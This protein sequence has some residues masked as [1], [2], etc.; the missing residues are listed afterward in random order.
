M[1]QQPAPEEALARIAAR[2][3]G[4]ITQDQLLRSGITPSG[5]SRRVAAGRLHRVH[6]AVYAVGHR[7]LAREGEWIAAVKTCGEGAVLSHR[8]AGALWRMIS[9]AGGPIDVT[10]PR[11]G[12][13]ERR[14]GIRVHR[15]ATLLPS[16]CTLRDGIPVTNPARTLDDLHRV[17]SAAGFAAALREAEYLKLPIGQRFAPDR[18]R[19]D[20]EARFIALCRRHRLPT[21][22][23]NV[24]LGPFT[25]DFLWADERLV[26]EVDGWDSHR[27]RSAFEADRARDARLKVLGYDVLRFT[28]R[29]LIHDAGAVVSTLLALLAR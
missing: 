8:S 21:P 18:T 12:G 22:E 20:L 2:Q 24:R 6:R 14:R 27:T 5:I 10:I 19:S 4:I 25:V 29:Q 1:R 16:H 15:S 28:H 9:P 7:G 26:V 17:L 13:R 23:V 3:H 11:R